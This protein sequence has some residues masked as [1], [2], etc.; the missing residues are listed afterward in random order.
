MTNKTTETKKNHQHNEQNLGDKLT[1]D[2]L[3][4]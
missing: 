2:E 3:P 1:K 4:N